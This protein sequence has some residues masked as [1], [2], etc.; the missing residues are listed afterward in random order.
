VRKEIRCCRGWDLG[1]W[2]G[3]KRPKK[4]LGRRG[5]LGQIEL[6]N[7]RRGTLVGNVVSENRVCSQNELKY[8]WEGDQ[9]STT[10]PCL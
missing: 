4:G 6:K 9:V 8:G 3:R 5:G 10:D 1:S 7:W 2:S